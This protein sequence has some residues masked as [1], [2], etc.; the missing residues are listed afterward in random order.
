MGGFRQGFFGGLAQGE[1]VPGAVFEGLAERGARKQALTKEQREKRNTEFDTAIGDLQKKYAAALKTDEKGNTIETPASLQA[2]Y[3]LTQAL[4][5]RDTFRAPLS[6]PGIGQKIEEALR[7]K[8]KPQAQAVTTQTG[9]IKIPAE[10]LKELPP[11]EDPRLAVPAGEPPNPVLKQRTGAAAPAAARQPQ[12]ETAVTIPG[13]STTAKGPALN[14]KQ[15]REQAQSNQRVQEESKLLTSAAP[16]APLSPE[17]QA[18]QTAQAGAAGKMETIRGGL[19]AIRTFHPDASTEELE[20]LNNLYLDTQLG[21]TEKKGILKPLPGS[22]PYKA[23]D[24]LYYQSMQNSLTGAI[25]AE[26]MPEGYTPPVGRPLSPGAQAFQAMVKKTS[27][28]TLSPEEQAALTNYPKYVYETSTAPRVAG[29][30]AGA[31][32]RAEFQNVATVNPD[33]PQ[34]TIYMTAGQA[35]RGKYALPSSVGYQVNIAGHKSM[36]PRNIGDNMT[37]FATTR[38][39]IRLLSTL[40]DGLG[41]GTVPSLNALTLAWSRAIGQPVPAEFEAVKDSLKGELAKAY[42]GTSGTIPE[43]AEIGRLIDEAK[44]PQALRGALKYA[45][46]TIRVRETN[47]WATARMAGLSVPGKT[48]ATPQ[49][50]GAAAAR[51][52]GRGVRVTAPDGSIH[53]FPNQAAADRFRKAAG[54]Q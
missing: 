11:E 39:H 48:A 50:G 5:A 52:A 36:L 7:I 28:Q 38:G 14:A 41:T 54:I 44:S 4:Q 43:L 12:A 22:K 45:N 49:G 27:G 25:T 3:A 30:T 46:D 35:R 31:K 24:G 17:Q 33:N 53:T 47:L 23:P 34:E 37:A 21:T 2:K 15:L 18:V 19:K 1:S 6:K 26:P 9:G 8:K 42:S 32:A 40:I 10:S 16:N 29:Y 20:R 13:R 51:P